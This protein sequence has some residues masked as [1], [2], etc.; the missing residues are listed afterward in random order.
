MIVELK[1][2]KLL[3]VAFERNIFLVSLEKKELATHLK[4]FSTNITSI[5]FSETYQALLVSNF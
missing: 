1:Y 5:A 3:C 2:R 4:N